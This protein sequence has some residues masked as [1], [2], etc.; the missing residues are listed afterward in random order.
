MLTGSWHG[1]LGTE[2]VVLTWRKACNKRAPGGEPVAEEDCQGNRT[3]LLT[4]CAESRPLERPWG[5][6]TEEQTR[7]RSSRASQSVVRIL[8][9][10]GTSIEPSNYSFFSISFLFFFFLRLKTILFIQEDNKKIKSPRKQWSQM[11]WNELCMWDME[12]LKFNFTCKQA[13]A[14]SQALVLVE[15][16]QSCI[17]WARKKKSW[18]LQILWIQLNAFKTF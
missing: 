3:I 5:T 2:K 6:R 15:P 10:S 4:K 17:S 16:S 1:S 18:R 12:S 11:I 9:S 8:F 7:A 13:K 14:E